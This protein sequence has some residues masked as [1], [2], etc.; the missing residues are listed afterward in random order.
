[1]ASAAVESLSWPHVEGRVW[2]RPIMV[3]FLLAF[4]GSQLLTL[5]CVRSEKTT[6]RLTL[7]HM[8][9]LTALFITGFLIVSICD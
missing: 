3:W 2:E 4:A 5:A 8:A 1:M 7:L 6:L 9:I